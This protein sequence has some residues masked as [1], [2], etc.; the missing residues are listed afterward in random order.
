MDN[1]SF[2]GGK[3]KGEWEYN[4]IYIEREKPLLNLELHN[5]MSLMDFEIVS[6]HIIC[7]LT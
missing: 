7:P 3:E 2:Q 5:N 6:N 1:I 4:Q